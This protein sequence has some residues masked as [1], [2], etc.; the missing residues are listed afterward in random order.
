MNAGYPVN[1][2]LANTTPGHQFPVTSPAVGVS[3]N[4]GTLGPQLPPSGIV[5]PPSGLVPPSLSTA[6]A[7]GAMATMSGLT[8]SPVSA[9]QSMQRLPVTPEYG[10]VRRLGFT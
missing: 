1:P 7:P 3:A 5:A 4:G 8:T 2:T 9:Y 10:L 6:V